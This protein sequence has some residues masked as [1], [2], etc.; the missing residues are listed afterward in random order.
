MKYVLNKVYGWN[1]DRLLDQIIYI[2]VNYCCC[3]SSYRCQ[4]LGRSRNQAKPARRQSTGRKRQGVTSTAIW[5]QDDRLDTA[6]RPH[7][8]WHRTLRR[9]VW[10]FH[11][12]LWTHTDTQR[13]QRAAITKNVRCFTT[14]KPM[15]TFL[16]PCIYVY[17]VVHS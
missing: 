12:R 6:G 5:P 2:Q 15:N 7:Y 8:F 14:G 13:P 3:S 10:S 4:I 1:V 17:S 9:L 11:R 16:I